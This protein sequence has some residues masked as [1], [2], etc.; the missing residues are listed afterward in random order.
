MYQTSPQNKKN[1]IMCQYSEINVMYFLFSLLRIKGLYMFRALVAHPQEALHK[2][3]WYIACVLCQLAAPGL[4][5]NWCLTI[6]ICY[7]ARS[8]E[9]YIMYVGTTPNQVVHKEAGIQLRTA[10]ANLLIASAL[11]R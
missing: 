9:H 8:T 10:V 5:W 6:L 4:E 1:Y 3:T 11:T 7:D 2:G